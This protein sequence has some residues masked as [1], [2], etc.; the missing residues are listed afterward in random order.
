MGKIAKSCQQL[1]IA[2]IQAY[3][4]LIS[5]L[6]GP[7]CRFAPS[8]SEYAK[9]ALTQ[10]GLSGLGLIIKRIMRCHPFCQGGWDPVPTVRKRR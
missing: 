7:R 3:Q 2:L 10:H 4:Y 5:P 1:G 8:C 6:L 9:Q